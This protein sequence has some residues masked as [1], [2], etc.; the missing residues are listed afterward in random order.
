MESLYQNKIAFLKEKPKK[1]FLVS[2]LMLIFLVLILVIS[3]KVEIYDHYL[4]KG[5][6]DCEELCKIVV[7][8]PTEIDIQKIKYKNKDFNANILSQSVEIDKEQVISYNLYNFANEMDFKDKEIV[9][10][11]FYYN[12]QRILK[13]FID[14]IF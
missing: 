8:V 12:K 13:K 2:M 5:Y 4:T 1:L 11:N 3:F 10:L 7:A 9:D 6:V 14:K